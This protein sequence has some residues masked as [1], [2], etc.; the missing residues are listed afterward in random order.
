MFREFE[1][2]WEG[3][4]PASPQAVW[5]AM[6]VHAGGYLWPIEYEPRVGGRERGLT[7]GGGFVSAWQPGR[8]FATRTDPE[9]ERDGP[10]S[11]DVTLE[12]LGAITYL[13][14]V[15]RGTVAAGDFGRQ[16][17]ACRRHT[18]FYQHSLGQYACHFGGREPVYLS[19]EAPA[20]SA[21][22]GFAVVRRALG[23]ADDVVGGDP[24]MLTPAGLD[25]VEGVCDYA[26][27]TFLGVRTADSLLRVYGR[28]AW[29]WP[30]SVALHLFGGGVDSAA[31]EQAWAGWIAGV[32]ERERVV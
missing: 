8:H 15:H 3:E 23:V 19:V 32:F 25:P 6:T 24:V 2:R 11:I 13:R 30:V 20:Q 31:V 17:D 27:G 10:N 9:T 18:T 21:E 4:L 5:D 16:L 29:G 22:G 26:I 12:P 7:A 1:V 14:Y 28:D